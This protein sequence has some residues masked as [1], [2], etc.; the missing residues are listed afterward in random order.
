SYLGKVPVPV[1]PWYWRWYWYLGTDAG[2]STRH[3][4]NFHGTSTSTGA[5]TM[6]LSLEILRPVYAETAL[7]K[8]LNKILYGIKIIC[9]IQKT[10]N[11][12]LNHTLREAPDSFNIHI[13]LNMESIEVVNLIAKYLDFT[14]LC[15]AQRINTTFNFCITIELRSLK[16]I[17]FNRLFTDECYYGQVFDKIYVYCPNLCKFHHFLS[18]WDHWNF[19]QSRVLHILRNFSR[20]DIG[21]DFVRKFGLGAALTLIEQA[22]NLQQ[23]FLELFQHYVDN[24]HICQSLT[25]LVIT[26]GFQQGLPPLW[27]NLPLLCTNLRA[28][29]IKIGVPLKPEQVAQLY[30]LL[31]VNRNLEELKVGHLQADDLLARKLINL[32]HFNYRQIK[33]EDAQMIASLRDLNFWQ[34]SHDGWTNT[35]TLTMVCSSSLEGL[36]LYIGMDVIDWIDIVVNNCPNLKYLCTNRITGEKMRRLGFTP[37]H[38]SK[39]T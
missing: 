22:A 3:I 16:C 31:D 12:H 20:L 39:I 27:I 19:D 17:D 11:N 18:D 10:L 21:P 5:N 32:R 35:S 33:L 1:P 37:E 30:E 2:T 6:V 38:S 9:P 15:I 13:F 28:L 4:T 36:S 34:L 23:L 8:N 29:N 14:Q 7:Y 25:K 26:S 24:I